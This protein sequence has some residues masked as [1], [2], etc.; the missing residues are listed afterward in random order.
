MSSDI[1]F[2]ALDKVA[3]E[4]SKKA[5]ENAGEYHETAKIGVTYWKNIMVKSSQLSEEQC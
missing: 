3:T 2:L 5:Q 1:N 4:V